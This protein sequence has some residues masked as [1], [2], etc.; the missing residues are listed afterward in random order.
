[1]WKIIAHELI[2][3]G[4]DLDNTY[5]TLKVYEHTIIVKSDATILVSCRAYNPSYKNVLF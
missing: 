5:V 2:I 1:M 3:D 4:H